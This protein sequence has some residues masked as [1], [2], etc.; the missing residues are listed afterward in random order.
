MFDFGLW[1][2][3]HEKELTELL[4]KYYRQ[5][6][7]FYTISDDALEHIKDAFVVGY[8]RGLHMNLSHEFDDIAKQRDELQQLEHRLNRRAGKLDG[9]EKRLK[10]AQ[11]ELLEFKRGLHESFIIKEVTEQEEK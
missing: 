2:Q 1:E 7:F 6:Q 9:K 11:K 10:E 4:I 5:L 3:A 8:K